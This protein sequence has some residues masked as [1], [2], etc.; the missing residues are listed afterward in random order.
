LTKAAPE[1]I[2]NIRPEV[3]PMAADSKTP[4]ESLKHFISDEMI[5]RIVACTNQRISTKLDIINNIQEKNTYN[6]IQLTNHGEICSLIGLFYLRGLIGMNHMDAK[7]FNDRVGPPAFT[8][9]MSKNRFK[10]LHANL[11]FDDLTTR[12]DRWPFDRFTA[13]RT[14][15]EMFNDLCS[16]VLNPTDFLALDET[17]FSCRNQIAFKQYNSNKPAK[18]GLLYRSIN[19]ARYP[20]TYR[21]IV[22]GGKPQREPGPY[23]VPGIFPSVVRLVEGL[24]A[25]VSLKRLNITMDRLYTGFDLIDWL[26]AKKITAVGTIM[27]N[28]K[29]IPIE[30]KSVNERVPNS[31]KVAW[32]LP[33]KKV[34]LHS[35][36]VKTK[37]KGMK[38]VLALSTF[39]PVL[40]ITRDD[41]KAK[42][43]MLKFYDFTKGGTNIVDQRMGSYSTNTKS[44]KWTMAAFSYI[45]DTARV[46]SQTLW[47]LNN[48]KDPTKVNSFDFAYELSMSLLLPE[49]QKREITPLSISLKS[50]ITS[51]LKH[52]TA[53]ATEEEIDAVQFSEKKKRCHLPKCKASIKQL[54]TACTKNV[55]IKHSKT[56]CIGCCPI[57]EMVVL[58]GLGQFGMQWCRAIPVGRWRG[59]R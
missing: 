22:I 53:A 45:L 15:Y 39:L 47:A 49:I 32:E 12:D 43:A 6:Y 48:K 24:E 26:L 8:C 27:S 40:G 31:Y 57:G 7:L 28:R 20:Y 36:V 4:L 56:Y 1:N 18:Y 41:G 3:R 55:C 50:K 13:I 10:F 38:N 52:Q 51:F 30:I 5:D 2:I 9:T 35:Y 19:S 25:H 29:G 37:S 44:N 58:L 16:G 33:T 23:Y 54:C 46:N 34:S 11:A 59:G 14:F 17:L 21:S 42:P